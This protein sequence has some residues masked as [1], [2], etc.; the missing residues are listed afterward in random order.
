MF[1]VFPGWGIL[2]FDEGAAVHGQDARELPPSNPGSAGD[3]GGRSLSGA[4][5]ACLRSI[6]A[7][8]NTAPARTELTAGCW[9]FCLSD[10]MRK[11]V[12][13]EHNWSF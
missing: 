6:R 4:Q 11:A 9:K 7:H 3:G 5:A 8:T 12:E 1:W 13:Q 2:I 10:D